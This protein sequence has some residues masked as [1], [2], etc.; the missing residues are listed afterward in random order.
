M[1]VEGPHRYVTNV[2]EFFT[3]TV[4]NFLSRTFTGIDNRE[5]LAKQNN[6]NL[7]SQAAWVNAFQS[8]N[9]FAAP[10]LPS[11]TIPASITPL[12]VVLRMTPEDRVRAFYQFMRAVLPRSTITTA[13]IP[14]AL[15]VPALQNST[16]PASFT[17]PGDVPNPAN[18]AFMLQ[19][20]GIVTGQ[21]N[22]T[23][24]GIALNPEA[25]R[26]ARL[27]FNDIYAPGTPDVM[28]EDYLSGIRS[29]RNRF[30]DGSPGAPTIADIRNP[31][32]LMRNLP[33]ARFRNFVRVNMIPGPDLEA[34]RKTLQ[35]HI[36]RVAS[37]VEERDK[38]RIV[39]IQTTNEQLSKI[40]TDVTENIN[41]QNNT[42][43]DNFRTLEPWQQFAAMGIGAY[44]LYKM[45]NSQNRVINKIPLALLGTYGYLRLVNGDPN[46]L[47][48]MVT[49]VQGALAPATNLIG[50]GFNRLGL[51]QSQESVDRD[52]LAIM[53]R[54]FDQKGF[55]DMYPHSLAFMTLSEVP[56]RELGGAFRVTMNGEDQPS[57]SMYSEPGQPLYARMEG[58]IRTRRYDRNMVFGMFHQNNPMISGALGTVFYN[59]AASRPENR[60][61]AELVERSRVNSGAPTLGPNGRMQ[62]SYEMMR[63]P[64][65]RRAYVDL[66]R[67]GMAL[68]QSAQYANRPFHEVI[69]ELGQVTPEVQP[70]LAEHITYRDREDRLT[71]ERALMNLGPAEAVEANRA[72]SLNMLK[73]EFDQS[74][75]LRLAPFLEAPGGVDRV[76]EARDRILAGNKPLQETRMLLQQLEYTLFLAAMRN[77][78]AQLTAAN[79]NEVIGTNSPTWLFNLADHLRTWTE[80]NV[81]GITSSF[82]R[83][84]GIGDVL[85][86]ISNRLG[87][88]ITGPGTGFETLRKD[89][90]QRQKQLTEMRTPET[91]QKLLVSA[92]QSEDAGAIARL[93]GTAAAGEFVARILNTDEY[94]NNLFNHLEQAYAQSIATDIAE[95][96]VTTHRRSGPPYL[97][98]SNPTLRGV[99]LVEMN[100]I[101]MLA[102]ERG[103]RMLGVGGRMG[104]MMASIAMRQELSSY[105]PAVNLPA[106]SGIA[107]RTKAVNH[108]RF[109]GALYLTMQPMPD[110][111]ILRDRVR[112]VADH[113]V[114]AVGAPIDSGAEFL[115]QCRDIAGIMELFNMVAEPSYIRLVQVADTASV[116]API[117][118]E[119]EAFSKNAF[120]LNEKETK[121]STGHLEAQAKALRAAAEA[122]ANVRTQTYSKDSTAHINAA[123]VAN[124]PAMTK[125]RAQHIIDQNARLDTARTDVEPIIKGLRTDITDMQ[126]NHLTRLTALRDTQRKEIGQLS[127]EFRKAIAAGVDRVTAVQNFRKRAEEKAKEFTDARNKLATAL[128]N[129]R[130]DLRKRITN[131]IATH[132]D[133][134]T[135][136]HTTLVANHRTAIGL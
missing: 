25:L 82:R 61:Q 33:D 62:N 26:I 83:V 58:I 12:D 3:T 14:A 135:K 55:L 110:I 64:A 5:L 57:M 96:M 13:P 32:Y 54:Y 29:I 100:N 113:F 107:E 67:R 31:E 81:V 63:D 84:N 48:T 123:P 27:A 59:L 43:M 99:T 18:L 23:E 72:A 41:R 35:G 16:L 108:L 79:V 19:T 75:L 105:D 119:F 50:R 101:V 10:R 128:S 39:D 46:A 87:S 126:A 118:T 47:N 103:D 104:G 49:A 34:R 6:A 117:Q 7:Q 131:D 133:T 8:P 70:D 94:R 22:P 76:N 86:I 115:N 112:L 24:P 71:A 21:V 78:E 124:R 88:E 92:L 93:G 132:W 56:M 97:T 40:R 116:A 37:L 114:P 68:A 52:R 91:A 127:E 60:V 125:M 134:F 106:A 20:A 73:A 77:G 38:K 89:L 15:N 4:P 1:G 45:W 95:A 65:A 109:L 2:Q 90:E 30:P 44:A 111:D 80:R 9:V 42:F 28:F 36:D 98:D 136:D 120:E 11:T 121:N 69:A 51:F 130:A 53:G 17:V 85:T 102:R 122:T 66:V 129:E 74:V